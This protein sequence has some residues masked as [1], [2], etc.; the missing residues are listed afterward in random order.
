MRLTENS[1]LCNSTPINLLSV[2]DKLQEERVTARLQRQCQKE[3]ERRRSEPDQDKAGLAKFDKRRVHGEKSVT[4]TRSIG[5]VLDSEES[6][7]S[8]CTEH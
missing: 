3:Q 1:S 4:F 2:R 5:M 7:M 8:T 6:I